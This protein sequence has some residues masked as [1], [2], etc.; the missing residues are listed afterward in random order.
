MESGFTFAPEKFATPLFVLRTY[1]PGDGALV[2]EAVNA[3]YDHLKRFMIWAQ[4]HTMPDDSERLVRQWRAK[5]LME[6]DFAIGIF[7][8]DGSR[9]LGS[10]GFHP[11]GHSL[12]QPVAEIGMWIRVE[13][14]GKGLGTAALKAM[15][16]W[17]FSDWLWQ[18]LYWRCDVENHASARTAEKAGMT[19]E[20]IVRWNLLD[21]DNMYRDARFYGMFREDWK[22]S[23]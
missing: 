11:R 17:G 3:S 2:N 15:L 22:P 19:F 16:A 10:T 13:E 5:Y 14:A 4:P 23:P 18:R 1:R 20:G 12:V 7:A 8:P 6:E 9:L 21:R